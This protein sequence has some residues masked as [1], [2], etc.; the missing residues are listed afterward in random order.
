LIS[1]IIKDDFVLILLAVLF[2]LIFNIKQLF[3]LFKKAG[4]LILKKDAFQF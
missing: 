2:Y 1:V 4:P 3:I